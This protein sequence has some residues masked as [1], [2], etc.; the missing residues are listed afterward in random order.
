[1]DSGSGSDMAL[2]GRLYDNW[3]TVTGF[4][5]AG[6]HPMWS[7]QTTNLSS[8]AATWQCS[9]CHGWD[10]KGVGGAYSSG[11]HET[12][13]A[14]VFKS[15]RTASESVLADVI[16]GGVDFRH[17]FS[18]YLTD[19]QIAALAAFLKAGVVNLT[20]YIDYTTKLPSATVDMANGQLLYERLCSSCHGADGKFLNSGSDTE[21]VYI[22]T[23]ALEDPWEYVHNTRFGVPESTG[24]PA[25]DDRGWSIPDTIDVL[26][27][28][29]TLPAE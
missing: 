9:E 4:V 11:P 17:D 7:E 20:P 16:K 14:G 27:Y 21:P 10:Y 25:T 24:M 12:G 2:G 5:P 23:A 22:G 28:S 26:G 1:M 19:A 29:Q 8:G 13:F 18:P 3:M 6:D 15:A